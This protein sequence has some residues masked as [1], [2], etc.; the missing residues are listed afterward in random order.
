MS[1]AYCRLTQDCNISTHQNN[2]FGNEYLAMRAHL[3]TPLWI[4]CHLYVKG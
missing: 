3:I 1:P 2:G 4:A